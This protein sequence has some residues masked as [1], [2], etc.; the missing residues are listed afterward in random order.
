MAQALPRDVSVPDDVPLHWQYRWRDATFGH[1]Q[2]ERAWMPQKT[3]S[4][5]TRCPW[6]STLDSSAYQHLRTEDR[7]GTRTVKNSRD[8][9]L[10]S[11]MVFFPLLEL[12]H[13]PPFMIFLEQPHMIQ[14]MATSW[15]PSL[16]L[17]G[18]AATGT[19][20][21]LVDSM[22]SSFLLL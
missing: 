1:G 2:E 22:T 13:L 10:E 6:R 20:A 15:P 17:I 14:T 11:T 3:M 16:A 8:Q 18:R 12:E 19:K 5:T 7:I 4:V 21:Q 9:K